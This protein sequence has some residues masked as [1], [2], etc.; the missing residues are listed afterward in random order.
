M[1]KKKLKRYNHQAWVPIRLFLR[2]L[3]KT[4]GFTL[5]VRLDHVEGHENI[6]EEGPVIFLINHIAFVDPIAVLFVAKRDIVPLA[7]MEVYEIPFLGVFPRLWGVIP[8]KRDEIDRSAIRQAL[9]VL[10]AGECL[11]VAPEGTRGDGLQRG[12]DGAAYLA[13]RSGASIVPVAIEGTV[14]FPVFRTDKRWKQPGAHIRFG[15]PFR[16]KPE[17]S[18]AKGETLKKMTDEAMYV[19]AKTLPEHRR[20]EYADF[21]RASEDTLE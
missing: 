15:K 16:Y 5:L 13:S 3:L 8:I 19:L 18:H 21:S 11:L 20:G 7:K 6:P 1:S 12:R 10:K 2:F 17:F 14:G 4:I 9:E